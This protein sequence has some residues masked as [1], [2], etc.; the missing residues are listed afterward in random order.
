MATKEFK[1]IQDPVNGPVKISSDFQKIMDSQEFQRLR[2][3]K[4][5]GLCNLVF[6]GANH[7]RFEH[8]LGAMHLANLFSEALNID[9]KE[10][11][12]VSALLHDV[13]HPPLSHSN[14]DI[15]RE[16]TGMDH[17]EAGLGIITGS[18][19]FDE[20]SL[21]GILESI[22][23]D[24]SDVA[25]VLKGDRNDLRLLSRMVSGPID[26][27]ELDYMRRDSLY[28]GV[29]IGNV[30]HRRVFNVAQKHH[31]DI[32]IEEKGL[33]TLES[34]LIAR[35]LMYST[36][37]FHKT[38]RI[39]Q[40]MTG[41]VIRENREMLTNPFFM[42]DTDLFHILKSLKENRIARAIMQR[43]LFKPVA[44]VPYLKETHRE[45][46]EILDNRDDLGETD[47]IIDVIPPVDFTGPGR[48]KSDLR[49]LKAE[50]STEITEV[51]PLIRALR[52]T[53]E[54]RHIMVSAA[55]WAIESVKSAIKG[56]IGH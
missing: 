19:I 56:L 24:P 49:V 21:P 10:L 28:C 13:G 37:Y 9:Q 8:S 3:I 23:I 4:S 55:P 22:G 38:S 14:E 45:L 42:D 35:I 7:T 33:G 29:Q 50:G 32:V 11:V 39:A 47:Y 25:S 40:I 12:M 54:N 30:D 31:N 27:D 17:L 1:I 20:S 43:N 2:Y 51:S 52:E 16:I 18:G 34:I 5:L 41:Y 46:A 53:L 36:V 48:V 44:R 26:V 6:P 15:F